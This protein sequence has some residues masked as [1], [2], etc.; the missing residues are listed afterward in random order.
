MG[1]EGL[2]GSCWVL[3]LRF[4][5]GSDSFSS[6]G[7]WSSSASPLPGR[8]CA[9]S[10]WG[11]PSS[12]SDWS[13]SSKR[14]WLPQNPP[15]F[16]WEQGG[17][18]W[19]RNSW[20]VFSSCLSVHTGTPELTMEPLCLPESGHHIS[21]QKSPWNTEA[22]E[23]FCSKIDLSKAATDSDSVLLLISVHLHDFNKLFTNGLLCHRPLSVL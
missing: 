21:R 3:S 12:Q 1:K 14:L 19:R 13:H 22:D 15:G 10:R 20:L 17:S 18:P 6:H 16:W 23:R 7:P 11:S 2:A 5:R 4:A 8:A 9:L